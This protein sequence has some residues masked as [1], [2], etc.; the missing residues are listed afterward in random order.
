MVDAWEP[1]EGDGHENDRRSLVAWLNR[2]LGVEHCVAAPSALI[3]ASNFFELAVAA[4]LLAFHSP[5]AA[6]L[7]SV[8]PIGGVAE[9]VVASLGG[10]PAGD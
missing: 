9:A 8:D 7:V 10:G 5:A 2:R 1:E 6:G 3:G 4:A